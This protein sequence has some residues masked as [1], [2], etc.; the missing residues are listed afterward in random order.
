MKETKSRVLALVRK[1]TENSNIS[2]NALLLDEG[3]IDSLT[4]VILLD[5]L[6]VEFSIK[7]DTDE[8]T[9]ENF[10]TIENISKLI[11]KQV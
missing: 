11:L 6:E 8:L 3:W 2:E 4:A 9:H 5:E 10:N 1:I 7:M